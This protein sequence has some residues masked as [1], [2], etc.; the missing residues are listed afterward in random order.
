MSEIDEVTE[1]D[2]KK[3]VHGEK[4]RQDLRYRCPSFLSFH[5]H[6]KYFSITEQ[7]LSPTYGNQIYLIRA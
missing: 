1:I 5:V 2:L 4:I 3:P 7:C 6:S